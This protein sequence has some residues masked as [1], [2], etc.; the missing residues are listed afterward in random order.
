M[1]HLDLIRITALTAMLFNIVL[2]LLVL[3]RDY[4]STLHRV[5][6]L[7][8][9][10]ISLWNLGAYHLSQHTTNNPF[11]WAKILQL[12]V[13]FIPLTMFHLC[14]VISKTRVGIILPVLYGAHILLASTLCFDWYITGIKWLPVGY[15]SIPGP[16]FHV[17]TL[18]YIGLTTGIMVILFRKLKVA[19]PTQRTRLRALRLAVVS[20]WVFG[21]NDMMPIWGLDHYPLTN[22]PFYP[23]GSLAAIFYVV[24]VGYSVLQHQLL[25]IHVTLSRFAAQFVRLLFMVLIGFL[26]LLL[27]SRFN[28]GGF[29]TFSFVA[30]MSALAASAVVASLFFPQFFGKGSDAL[31]RKILGDRFEYHAR[32]SNLIEAMKSFPE[33]E[34]L[35]PELDALLINTMMVRSYEIVLLEDATRA[36]VLLHSH[37][38]GAVFDFSGFTIDS[39]VFKYFQQT[40]AKS[41]SCN[42]VY[43][44]ERESLLQR[45]A[46]QQ[47]T[48]FEAEFCFPFFA[49]NDLVGMLLLGPKQNGDLFTPHDLRLLTEMS[50]S[51]GLLLNQIRLRSQLQAVYEQDLMGR[52]SRGLAHDLNNLLTPVQTLLQLLRETGLNQD[53]INE[54]LPVGLRNLDTV[55]TYVNEALFFSNSSKLQGKLGR[56][57]ETVREAIALVHGPAEAK[58]IALTFQGDTE[59]AIEMDAVLIKRLL[60]NLLSNAVDA[61]PSGSKID[62]QLAPLPKTEM[63]RDWYRLKVMD[64]GEGIS[65]ENL[66]RVFTP[67]FTT[68][69]T[70]DGKRGFGL[71]LAIARKIVHL[72]GGN[73][74]IA[75]KEHKGTTVQVDLPTRLVPT[76]K[77]ASPE[78]AQK[79]GMV[80]A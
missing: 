41:L 33:P 34:Y 45:D 75:S 8:G 49:G 30:A 47:L 22:I 21:S 19:A 74:S 18:F 38:A 14:L 42:L 37:P 35:L 61:S 70:G 65:Q 4:R 27:M 36:F 23:V 80:A 60:C 50:S 78:A 24:I 59:V 40:G 56:L 2:T 7:W 58:G 66:R 9:L 13:I 29:S 11:F 15:W 51:L 72:H 54:L 5:Y 69:N 73:L 63:N 10:E 53:T 68:K 79:R 76:Q 43:D 3:G 57:D 12:G 20:L 48:G 25:D 26:L 6:M 31:E 71:G 67:Y 28:P 32:V 39:P 16:G 64:Q 77:A 62:V 1:N 44:S 17:F 55:R 46:R 52:M